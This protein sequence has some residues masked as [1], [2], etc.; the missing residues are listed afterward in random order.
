MFEEDYEMSDKRKK[1]ICYYNDGIDCERRKCAKC[2]WDPSVFDRRK[3]ETR[4]RL[5]EEARREADLHR[6][7]R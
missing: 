2:G 3:A 6:G 7:V 5:Q 4:E 1:G